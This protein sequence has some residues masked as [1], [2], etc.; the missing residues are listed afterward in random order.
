[1]IVDFEA[2]TPSQVYYYMTQTLIPR[3]IAWI[4]SENADGGLNLAP[5][6]YFNAVCSDP[7]LVMFS[8][9]RKPDDRP[10]DTRVNI[11]ERGHFVIHIPRAT[12]AE[13]VT[14][15]SAALPAG[16]SE[17]AE[18]ALETVAFDGFDLPRLVECPIAYG[19]RRWEVREIGGVQQAL[20]LGQIE[21]VFID[22]GVTSRDAKNRVRVDA[23]AVEPL[24]RL[25]PDEYLVD[26]KVLRIKR[27]A[28]PHAG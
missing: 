9:G 14:A 19:C 4:L 26:G 24:G 15:S 6:S 25:G 1:M 16:D 12:Q 23:A 11:E 17:I 8:I 10:K 18:L 27:P 28:A 22:E 21:R 13:A 3:P 7:P 20:I 2:L 5:F